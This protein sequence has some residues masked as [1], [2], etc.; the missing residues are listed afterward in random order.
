MRLILSNRA[1]D[2]RNI[3]AHLYQQY[4]SYII[5]NL[6]RRDEKPT[7]ASPK[8]IWVL[9]FN[10]MLYLKTKMLEEILCYLMTK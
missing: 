3:A 4:Y 2:T 8:K 6:S 10:P 9:F 1:D 5:G 7:L